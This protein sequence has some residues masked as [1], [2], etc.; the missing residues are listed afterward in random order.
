MSLLNLIKFYYNNLSEDSQ[1]LEMLLIHKNTSVII[2][3]A[4]G[5]PGTLWI[6]TAQQTI[7]NW[8]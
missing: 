4:I 1:K 2:Y 3:T 6:K 8:S 5:H 7:T